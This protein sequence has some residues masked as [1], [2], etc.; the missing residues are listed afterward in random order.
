VRT[1]LT[2][3]DAAGHRL[4]DC[5]NCGQAARIELHGDRLRAT[6]FAGCDQDVALEGVDVDHLRVECSRGYVGDYNVLDGVRPFAETDGDAPREV[7]VRWARDITP[8]PVRFAWAERF[9]LGALALVAGEGGLGKS[10]LLVEQHARASRGEL[11]GELEGEPAPSLIITSEDHAASVVIPRL[12]V[13]GADLDLVGVVGINAGG[14]GGLVTFPDDLPA[15]EERIR[16]TGARLLS[17]DPVVAAL[18]G[19][20]DSHK[21]HS[22]R[23]VLGPL[24][25]LAERC[26]VA[27]VGVT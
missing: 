8:E 4:V 18:S 13:A 23:R 26:N 2:Y 19:Q 24:A 20:V 1:R 15:L 12:I 11:E 16:E 21:D 25:L 7:V 3:L 27:V 5:Q 22:I 6:C 9:P 14:A 10:T 17:I